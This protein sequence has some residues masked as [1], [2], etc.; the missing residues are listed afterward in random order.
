MCAIAGIIGKKRG[1][2]I[3]PKRIDKMI[4]SIKHRGPDDTGYYKTD[5]VHLAMARLSI[6]DLQS[7]G[8]CPIVHKGSSGDQVLLYNGEIYNYI[9]LRDEL[10]KKGYTFNTDCDSEVL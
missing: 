8:L 7:K 10:R 2:Q 6:I 9:E 5:Q 1:I 4:L 3:E